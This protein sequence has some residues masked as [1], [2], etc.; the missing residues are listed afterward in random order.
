MVVLEVMMLGM[1]SR[2]GYPVPEKSRTLVHDGLQYGLEI[3]PVGGFAAGIEHA[4][5]AD[6]LG[7]NRR[8]MFLDEIV[9]S[10]NFVL[11]KTFF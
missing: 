6:D 1:T 7:L 10:R 4:R 11:H 9:I 2:C 8:N 5:C 3:T